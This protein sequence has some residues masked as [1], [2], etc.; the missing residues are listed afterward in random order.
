SGIGIVQDE[1][2]ASSSCLSQ[3]STWLSC[4]AAIN[5]LSI[6]W[7]LGLLVLTLVLPLNL[8]VLGAIWALVNQAQ[9]AQRASL[10]Y[11]AQS[12]AAGVDAEFGKYI[13]V[14]QLLARSPALRDDN[15]AAFEADV[16]NNVPSA[17]SVWVV[18]ADRNAQQLV[19]TL[20]RPNQPLPH[21]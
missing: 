9:N 1:S 10:L 2:D 5:R 14:A 3:C 13:A 19:N 17:R 15:L 16:R 12:I 6:P 8:I 7:R 4:K 21:R 18:V 20:A 11:A